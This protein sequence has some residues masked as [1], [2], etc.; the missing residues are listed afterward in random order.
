[1]VF[2]P[3]L[4]KNGGCG[5]NV[6]LLNIAVFLKVLYNFNISYLYFVA[7]ELVGIEIGV[8]NTYAN[9]IRARFLANSMKIQA[10]RFFL[11]TQ[12]ARMKVFVLH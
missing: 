1:M 9:L 12:S 10:L 6:S 5:S 8:G 11:A 2:F 3:N 4:F 7:N